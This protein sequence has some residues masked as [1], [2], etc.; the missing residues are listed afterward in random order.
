VSGVKTATGAIVAALLAACAAPAFAL[1]LLQAWRDALANDAQVAS[2]RSQLEATR[3]R[4]PQAR[5][6]LLPAVGASAGMNRVRVDPNRG[7]DR[8]FTSEAYAIQLSVPLLSLPEQQAWEQSKLGVGIAEAQYVQARQDL[9]LRVSRAYFDVL[10]AQD[11][12]ETIRAQKR[13]ISEQL[14]AAKR[15]FEVGT[16]TIT[17]Q[18]EAQARFDLTV[19]QEIAATN[20]LDV[21]RALLAQLV[22]RPT[23]ELD[24]LRRGVLLQPPQPTSESAWVQQATDGSLAVQQQRVNVEIARH[25]IERRRYAKYP[26]VD[27]VGSLAR[28]ENA[29][30]NAVGLRTNTASVGVQ[31]SIPLYT[32]GGIDASVR[33]AAALLD[34]SQSDLEN[35]RR[36]V[37][38]A[39]RQAYL[40]VNSSLAQVSALEA[41]ERSSQLALE[42]NLLGYQVGVRINIDVL[43]A[44]QELF[45]TRLD[46]ARARYDVV[47]NGLQL[48]S[49][50]GTL[51]AEDV[52]A[53]DALLAPPSPGQSERG[54]ASSPL[55]STP[56]PPPATSSPATDPSPP[57]PATP[58]APAPAR[59][60]SPDRR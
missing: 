56:L 45:S 12:L 28:N 50:A 23:G 36:Q 26:T 51:G 47:V 41:A 31:L 39:T 59:P 21:Q 25:E 18:Q 38:Q 53:V 1:D 10:A 33:E 6:Q 46:L 4:V 35:T 22:G 3:E 20:A 44:Q 5:S 29:A 55:P 17:D 13:A 24:V 11:N 58:K 15:N 40:G 52:A 8:T 2:A 48:K 19:A 57:A 34:R 30:L 32:G 14:E 60:P 42:S 54:S 7:P 27:L 49:T 37:E 43:N 16:A 9:I